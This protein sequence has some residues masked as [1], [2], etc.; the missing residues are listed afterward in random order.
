MEQPASLLNV[1]K[2]KRASG[3]RAFNA[4]KPYGPFKCGYCGVS[5][6]TH[7]KGEGEMFCSR[8]CSHAARKTP[9]FSKV[10]FNMC[11][12]CGK[13]WC[14]DR[15]ASFCNDEC[16]REHARRDTLNHALKAHEG[17]ACICKC[18]SATFAPEYGSKRRAFCSDACVKVNRQRTKPRGNNAQRA[19]RAGN[20]Y[21]HFNELRIF[22]RDRWKCQLCGVPTPQAKRGKYDDD[23]PEI[24]HIVSIADG[25]AHLPE[26]VQCA[27]RKC[28]QAKGAASRGQLWLAGF[29]DV[30]A[31]QRA[32]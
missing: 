21:S 30:P 31:T 12:T 26:N 24:D 13:R 15:A 23:A 32:A 2:G 20:S 10:A 4:A 16:K 6:L 18:C 14:S 8:V 17:K 5:Y 11:K 29:A 3:W 25:G 27:C 7:R 28:N 1:A 9:P 19:K 22:R